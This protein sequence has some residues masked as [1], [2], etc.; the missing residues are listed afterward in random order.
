MDHGPGK[1]QEEVW[2]PIAVEQQ[3][4]ARGSP[5]PPSVSQR[6]SA[7]RPPP[8]FQWDLAVAA[9]TDPQFS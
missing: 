8:R 3:Q 2:G 5:Q 9:R 4:G 1:S 7:S 6:G